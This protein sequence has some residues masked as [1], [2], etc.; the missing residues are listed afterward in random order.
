MFDLRANF[1]AKVGGREALQTAK[2]DKTFFLC[3]SKLVFD[4]LF[5]QF[6]RS[7]L[8]IQKRALER[9][10]VFIDHLEKLEEFLAYKAI[11]QKDFVQAQLRKTAKIVAIKQ[12]LNTGNVEGLRKL[13]E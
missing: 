4:R 7:R 1:V 2:H 13:T 3:V 9:R 10:K 11:K 12:V 5:E 6:P 8:V